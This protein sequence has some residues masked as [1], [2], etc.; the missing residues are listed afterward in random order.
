VIINELLKNCNTNA[1]PAV[2]KGFSEKPA[3]VLPLHF[4]HLFYA[5]TVSRKTN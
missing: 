5:E 3:G 1:R 2:S 4:L